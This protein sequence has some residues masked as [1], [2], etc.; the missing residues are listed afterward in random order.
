ME[1]T[2]EKV[3]DILRK[4][5]KTVAFTGAG[6][7]AESGIPTFRGDDGI[8]EKYDPICL[9]YDYYFQ[10]PEKAWPI[11]RELFFD[12]FGSAK[13]NQAHLNLALMESAG[14]I[15][16]IITQNID[17]L[18]QKAGSKKVI[19]FHGNSNFF[20]DTISNERFHVSEI[21]M[22]QSFPRNPSTGNLL[23]PDFVFFGES[24]PGKAYLESVELAKTASVF[25]V[26]GTT[27]EVVPASMIPTLAKQHGA[28]IIEI[29]TKP[30][31]YTNRVTDFFISKKASEALKLIY[32]ELK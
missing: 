5:K 22:K 25:L 8:W 32:E 28:V 29:N 10:Y 19:E 18:H 26:I 6:I 3:V 14:L 16:S 30:S 23:K 13:P 7:S 21:D 4:S 17:D 2:L 1:K 27:G 20:V 31:A 15:E 24:I 11:V 12:Y 9:D